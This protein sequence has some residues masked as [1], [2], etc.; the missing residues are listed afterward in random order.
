[1]ILAPIIEVIIINIT[2][3]SKSSFLISKNFASL[4]DSRV[5][6]IIP[7]TI[8]KPY[9]RISIGPIVNNI[10]YISNTSLDL[11][12]YYPDD[13]KKCPYY[14]SNIRDIKYGKQPYIDKICYIS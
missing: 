2:R 14:Y 5:A 8:I 7:I 3:S 9:D 13:Q 12:A 11:T 4:I 10:G 6:A 1:M